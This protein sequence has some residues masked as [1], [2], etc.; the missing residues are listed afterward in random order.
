MAG[1][2]EQRELLETYPDTVT[3]LLR[4]YAIEEAT[5]EEV[6]DVNFFRQSSN[7][8]KEVC[9]NHFWDKA[10]CCSTVF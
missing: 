2:G 7:T 4:T 6:G 3:I 1:N 10:L 5:L 9:S 8:T